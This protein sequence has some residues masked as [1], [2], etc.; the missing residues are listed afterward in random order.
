[1][2]TPGPPMFECGK[3]GKPPCPPEPCRA[4]L[5]KLTSIQ[6]AIVAAHFQDCFDAGRAHEKELYAA[7]MQEPTDT[8]QD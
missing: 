8:V 6:L 3:P 1:M 5:A 4:V 7:A 2:G